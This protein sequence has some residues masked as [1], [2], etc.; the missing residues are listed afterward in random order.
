MIKIY[1]NILAIVGVLRPCWCS[2]PT[3]IKTNMNEE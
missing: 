2:S 3:S 1:K